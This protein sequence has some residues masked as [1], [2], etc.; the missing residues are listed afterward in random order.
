M[1][2]QLD[3]HMSDT[4]VRDLLFFSYRIEVTIEVFWAGH[5]CD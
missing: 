2:A 5:Q 3:F 4:R 1:F